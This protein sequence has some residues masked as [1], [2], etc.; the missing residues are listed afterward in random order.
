MVRG[1]VSAAGERE[2]ASAPHQQRQQGAQP[3]GNQLQCKS[4]SRS[5]PRRA[6]VDAEIMSPSSSSSSPPFCCCCCC[7]CVCF[8]LF[9]F[10][11]LESRGL[12]G[13]LRQACSWSELVLRGPR[14]ARISACLRHWCARGSSHPDTAFTDQLVL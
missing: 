8:V 6:T 13:Y 9:L 14:T 10:F 12:K 4:T 5:N 2:A 7:C 11:G 1:T 3:A